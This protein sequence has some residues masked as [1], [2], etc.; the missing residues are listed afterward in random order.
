MYKLINTE[1]ILNF[2]FVKYS[3][4]TMKIN[5]SSHLKVCTLAFA[6]LNAGDNPAMD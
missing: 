4:A 5:K 1:K 6:E 3:K 2:I